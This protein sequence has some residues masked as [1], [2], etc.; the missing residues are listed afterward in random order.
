MKRP[1]QAETILRSL[2][3][4]LRQ[5]REAQGTGDG[6]MVKAVAWRI[7]F[8]AL[9]LLNDSLGGLYAR[10]EARLL[11]SE[12]DLAIIQGRQVAPCPR[13][14][15]PAVEDREGNLYCLSCHARTPLTDSKQAS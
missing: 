5:Y 12:V 13:C 2:E 6:L 15:M 9:A 4:R 14:A 8:G 3:T 10:E 7:V 1:P 11:L